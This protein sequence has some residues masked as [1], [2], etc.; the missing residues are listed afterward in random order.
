[1]SP[2]CFIVERLE[3]LWLSE[4]TQVEYLEICLMGGRVS[5]SLKTIKQPIFGMNFSCISDGLE[6]AFD[7]KL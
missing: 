1:M 6:L 5:T 3:P 7:W 4:G 2:V